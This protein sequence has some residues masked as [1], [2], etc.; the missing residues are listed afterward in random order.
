MLCPANSYQAIWIN[1]ICWIRIYLV[2][3]AYLGFIQPA[4]VVLALLPDITLKV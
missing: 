1:F 4:P 2:D 3:S